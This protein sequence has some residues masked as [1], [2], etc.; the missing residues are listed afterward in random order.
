M[1]KP[2][3]PQ[4]PN[5]GPIVQEAKVVITQDTQGHAHS[6]AR[7]GI[8]APPCPGGLEAGEARAGAQLEG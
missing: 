4:D 2:Q 6:E 3:A 8:P 1:P 5:Q 7:A